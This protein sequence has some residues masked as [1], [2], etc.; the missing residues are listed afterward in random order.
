MQGPWGLRDYQKAAADAAERRNLLVVLPTNSGKTLIA[1]ELVRRTLEREP[2][3]KIVF[4]AAAP[5]W[6]TPPEP[7]LA[8]PFRS[9]SSPAQEWLQRLWLQWLS[10]GLAG[11]ACAAAHC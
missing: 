8:A 3:R 4:A 5:G 2:R 7:Q 6:P 1:A 11:A 10:S 9:L